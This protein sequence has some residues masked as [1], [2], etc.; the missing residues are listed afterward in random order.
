MLMPK[1]EAVWVV[2]ATL[3]KGMPEQCWEKGC[4]AVG[5]TGLGDLRQWETREALK[6]AYRAAYP[7]A[8]KDEAVH[9]VGMLWALSHEILPGHWVVTPDS[10]GK[11]MVG[12]VTRGYHY[13]KSALGEKAPHVVSV[14]WLARVERK[15]LDDRLRRTLRCRLIVFRVRDPEPIIQAVLQQTDTGP[16][17]FPPV[18]A[19]VR[20]L[21]RKA[22][23]KNW[24]RTE[25]ATITKIIIPVLE[26]LGWDR[27]DEIELEYFGWKGQR[28]RS[29]V[30]G[31]QTLRV[32]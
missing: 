9:G 13:S 25:A 24:K 16:L 14:K 28:G 23:G 29:A 22:V 5:W 32:H 21:V 12:E 30:Q 20:E 15:V 3:W 11:L 17:P 27:L 4:V 10:E 31:R 26:K 2:R 6:D 18:A 8:T 1:P 7:A 19:E